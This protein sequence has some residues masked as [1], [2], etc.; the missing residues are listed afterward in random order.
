[1]GP[2]AERKMNKRASWVVG[3]FVAVAVVAA[4]VDAVRLDSDD[5]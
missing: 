5:G 2:A 4:T 1:M 3:G